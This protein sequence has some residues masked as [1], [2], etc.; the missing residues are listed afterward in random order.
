[1][2]VRLLRRRIGELTPELQERV[3]ALPTSQLEDLGE[4]LLQFDN[5]ADL[6]AWLDSAAY[7]LNNGAGAPTRSRCRVACACETCYTENRR[8]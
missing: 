1:M 6:A 5:A 8:P 3:A 2:I 7:G 4:A